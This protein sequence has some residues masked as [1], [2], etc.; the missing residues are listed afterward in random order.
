MV[1]TLRK[2]VPKK[3]Q[4]T[5]PE[6]SHMQQ[7]ARR[8]PRKKCTKKLPSRSCTEKDPAKNS[9]ETVHV[10]DCKG[11]TPWEKAQGKNHAKERTR[12]GSVDKCTGAT[13]K[14]RTEKTTAKERTEMCSAKKRTQ[15]VQRDE[16]MD[17]STA[18]DCTV[19]HAPR[20]AEKSPPRK[21]KPTVK[22][23]TKKC[24]KKTPTKERR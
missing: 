17:I 6:K 22:P 9:I 11:G 23:L 20:R 15:K 19:K 7:Y 3:P 13:L 21:K 14:K 1:N 18:K 2:N 12:N 5:S 8:R 10:K 4:R 24:T 16:P